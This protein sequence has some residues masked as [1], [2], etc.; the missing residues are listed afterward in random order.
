MAKILFA[1]RQLGHGK[2]LAIEL[3]MKTKCESQ[4][5]LPYQPERPLRFVFSACL[6]NEVAVLPKSRSNTAENGDYGL[7]LVVTN[8]SQIESSQ[9]GANVNQKEC[10]TV[11]GTR[12]NTLKEICEYNR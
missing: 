5:P 3:C 1:Y 12:N 2:G 9:G 7:D 4:K 8:I 6:R 10:Y 11:R